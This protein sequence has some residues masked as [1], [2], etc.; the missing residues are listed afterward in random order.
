[1]LLAGSN[2]ITSVVQ[3]WDPSYIVVDFECAFFFYVA[4]HFPEAKLIGCLFHCKKASRRK[5]KQLRFPYGKVQFATRKGVF[6]LLTVITLEL[7]TLGIGFVADTINL[8]L[9]AL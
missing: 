6:D 7:L 9:I 1:M 2:W 8:N 5:M 3:D 4:L